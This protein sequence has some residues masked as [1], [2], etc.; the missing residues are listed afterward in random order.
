MQTLT[1]EQPALTRLD[2]RHSVWMSVGL[3]VLPGL[4]TGAVY[5]LLAEPVARLGY[6][7][8][9]AL[10]A[11][12]VL[13][14]IPSELGVI[15]WAARKGYPG[16]RPFKEMIG[17]RE[18]LPFWQYLVLGPAILVATGLLFT[19]LTPVSG[20][21]QRLLGW[22]PDAMVLNIGLDGGFPRSILV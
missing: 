4:L 14:L 6:P 19:L 1:N 10:M 11:A 13:V 17:Y 12:G 7:S 20:F 22:L 18:R 16:P 9:A 15:A 21:L 8:I 5:Y 3:H 2:S